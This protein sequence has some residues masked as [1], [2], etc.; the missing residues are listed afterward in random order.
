MSGR[1]L[2]DAVIVD[3]RTGKVLGR[4]TFKDWQAC[5][6]ATYAE[7][8]PLERGLFDCFD[9]PCFVRGGPLL[10]CVDERWQDEVYDSPLAFLQA[11]DEAAVSRPALVQCADG[12][13]DTQGLVLAV[14]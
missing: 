6:T 1:L 4:A 9:R 14:L 10:C 13:R 11:C 5:M 12:W 7:P 2:R 8:D 3:A